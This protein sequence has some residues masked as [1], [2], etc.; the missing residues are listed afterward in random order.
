[1]KE[2]TSFSVVLIFI[3]LTFNIGLIKSG[4]KCISYD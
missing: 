4:Y 1:V 3:L 2:V